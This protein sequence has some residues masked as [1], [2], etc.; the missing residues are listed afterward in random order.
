MQKLIYYGGCFIVG[1]GSRY[2][3]E[4]VVELNKEQQERIQRAIKRR[5]EIDQISNE[6]LLTIKLH[7]VSKF[8]KQHPEIDP[9]ELFEL[10][11]LNNVSDI[12]E[13]YAECQQL[14]QRLQRLQRLQQ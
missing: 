13:R 12:A 5:D 14:Q 9:S 1:Y 11:D 4:K 10:V 7:Q 8:A 3:F 6:I 2:V